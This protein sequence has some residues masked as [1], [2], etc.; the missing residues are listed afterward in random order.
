MQISRHWRLNAQRYRLENVRTAVPLVQAQATQPVQA[1]STTVR[2][3]A[4]VAVASARTA[5]R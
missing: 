2:Q 3:Q 5:A 1:E 4:P